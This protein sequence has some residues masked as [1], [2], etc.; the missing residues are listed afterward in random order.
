[1]LTFLPFSVSWNNSSTTY[2]SC[3]IKIFPSLKGQN[4]PKSVQNFPSLLAKATKAGIVQII[5]SS[6][7][8]EVL[9]ETKWIQTF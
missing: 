4:M 3:Y 6:A 8:R 1:M 7:R 2:G 9:S 5:R